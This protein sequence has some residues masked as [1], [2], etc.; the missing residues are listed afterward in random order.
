M[1]ISFRKIFRLSNSA[2]MTL[3]P[4]HME[5]LGLEIGDYVRASVP[6]PGVIELTKA[7]QETE[8]TATM[9]ELST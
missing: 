2:V 3:S 8:D 1:Q 9:T 7:E 4:E 5:R 6:R